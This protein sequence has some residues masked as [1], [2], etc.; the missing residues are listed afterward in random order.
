MITLEEYL[1]LTLALVYSKHKTSDKKRSFNVWSAVIE[2]T[3]G[4]I[5]DSVKRGVANNIRRDN[6][7]I[8][9]I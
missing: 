5:D 8:F 9:R 2:D 4:I 1:K 3:I 7:E 6:I